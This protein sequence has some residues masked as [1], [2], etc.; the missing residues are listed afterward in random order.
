MDGCCCECHLPPSS[1]EVQVRRVENGYICRV[2]FP[3]HLIPDPIA[4]KAG[5]I[6]STLGKLGKGEQERQGQDPG[7]I[8]KALG[9]MVTKM[10]KVRRPLRK[11]EE[12]YIF[13]DSEAML[14]FIKE[15]FDTSEDKAESD[16]AQV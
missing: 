7:D 11:P 2:S 12:T 1:V 13:Q 14:K 5:D 10:K 16:E 6:F 4:E 8:F 15:T 3:K 9:D